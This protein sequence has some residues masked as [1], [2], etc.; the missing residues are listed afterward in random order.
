VKIR[1]NKF[2]KSAYMSKLFMYFIAVQIFIQAGLFFNGK[3]LSYYG[4]EGFAFIFLMLSFVI[5][6]V[7]VFCV[8]KKHFRKWLFYYDRLL[9]A[10][11]SEETANIIS[12][13]QHQSKQMYNNI[14][15][16]ID[17]K[18]FEGVDKCIKQYD[19]MS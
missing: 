19:E 11:I 14:M 1:G 6:A 9:E 15:N 8:M 18:D 10:K 2:I 17:K 4:S 3:L 13:A 12:L 7:I 5:G 16:A